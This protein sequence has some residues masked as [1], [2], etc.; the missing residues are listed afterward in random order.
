[1]KIK[2]FIGRKVIGKERANFYNNTREGTVWIIYQ[3][4]DPDVINPDYIGLVDPKEYDNPAVF[5]YRIQHVYANTFWDN[6][7]L[8]KESNSVASKKLM[9]MED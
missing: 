4:E 7:E 6:F 1:M 8:Y 9:R 3:A 2:D 5:R